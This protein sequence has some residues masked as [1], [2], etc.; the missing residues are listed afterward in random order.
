MSPTARHRCDTSSELCRSRPKRQATEMDPAPRD[1]LRCE[2]H[3]KQK[4]LS[5]V[6]NNFPFEAINSLPV[7]NSWSVPKLAPPEL[8]SREGGGAQKGSLVNS[9][10]VVLFTQRMIKVL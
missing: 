1:T 8:P 2:S 5:L 7:G 6:D 10:Y 9:Q 3:V 4:N